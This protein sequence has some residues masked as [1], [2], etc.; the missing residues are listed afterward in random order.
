MTEAFASG[1]HAEPWSLAALADEGGFDR[2]VDAVATAIADRFTLKVHLN[3]VARRLAYKAW[4]DGLQR[5][6][7]APVGY[8]DFVA[9]CANLIASLARHR[10]ISFSAMIR[11]PADRIIDTVLKYPNEV[12]ALAAGAALYMTR[13]EELTGA[14]PSDAP[15]SALVLENAA[16]NLSRH[17]GAA[18]KFRELLRLS[19]PWT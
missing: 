3:V 2:H 5:A 4:I 8:R 9:A 12:T 15:L 11:D 16:A 6:E 10:A 18:E 14:P 1:A 19:T 17:P 7:R 13:I